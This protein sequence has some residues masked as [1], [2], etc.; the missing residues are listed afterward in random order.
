MLPST[1]GIAF[2]CDQAETLLC[3]IVAYTLMHER[4]MRPNE[5]SQRRGS[6]CRRCTRSATQWQVL[7]SVS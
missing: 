1:A 4:Q 5:I 6:P 2:R 7:T 3:Y